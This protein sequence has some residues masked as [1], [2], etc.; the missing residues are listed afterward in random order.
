MTP[1][2][3]LI[4]GSYVDL[5]SVV[6]I[7]FLDGNK[8]AVQLRT[9]HEISFPVAD[10]AA[11]DAEVARINAARGTDRESDAIYSMLDREGLTR[12]YGR[13]AINSVAALIGEHAQLRELLKEAHECLRD[14]RGYI[15]G[16]TELSTSVD[17]LLFRIPNVLEATKPRK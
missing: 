1:L 10:R 5:D 6:F 16:Q 13:A 9:G 8:M 11:F 7:R 14:Y 15:M 3:K 12:G 2:F 17:K 4:T